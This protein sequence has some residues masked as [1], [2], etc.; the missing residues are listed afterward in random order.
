MRRMHWRDEE[1]NVSV[2][3]EETGERAEKIHVIKRGK[4]SP[5]RGTQGRATAPIKKKGN[6]NPDTGTLIKLR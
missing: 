2:G 6:H 1:G 3:R 4:G 5:G